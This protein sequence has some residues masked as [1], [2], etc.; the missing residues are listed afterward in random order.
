MRSGGAGLCRVSIAKIL[1]DWS[2]LNVACLWKSTRSLIVLAPI[3][4]MR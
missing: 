3:V 4:L 1:S 2:D